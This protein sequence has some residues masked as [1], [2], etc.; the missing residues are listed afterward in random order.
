VLSGLLEK[1]AETC[2]L[3]VDRGLPIDY[4]QLLS[5]WT[6]MEQST[7]VNQKKVSL[8]V[9]QEVISWLRLKMEASAERSLM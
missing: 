8:D 5:C 7:K 6:E 3:P 2:G 1:A 9:F 4:S